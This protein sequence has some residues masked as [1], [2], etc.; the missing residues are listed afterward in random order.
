MR[1]PEGIVA[2]AEKTFGEL[3]FSTLRRENFVQD[4]EGNLTDEMK[5]RT[6]DLKSKAQGMMIQVTIPA[7]AGEKDIP[8]NAVVK[9]VNPVLYTV[10][11]ASF[12]NRADVDWHVRADDII[13]A[14]DGVKG[15]V[16]A[17]GN[18]QKGQPGA[19]KTAQGTLNSEPGM[20]KDGK[21]DK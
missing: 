15:T 14:A 11:S 1:L 3:K 8:Y 21:K 18:I 9:L 17:S 12:G 13:L 7:E 19:D 4:E 2:D 10:A 16:D 5:G 6:Y 20:G